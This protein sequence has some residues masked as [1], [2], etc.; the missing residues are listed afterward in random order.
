MVPILPNIWSSEW[1]GR[2]R[3]CFWPRLLYCRNYFHVMFLHISVVQSRKSSQ[4]KKS[5]FA[6]FET[7]YDLRK[8]LNHRQPALPSP[9]ISLKVQLWRNLRTLYD[10]CQLNFWNSRSDF[11]VFLIQRLTS[12]YN[13]RTSSYSF[14]PWIVSAHLCTEVKGHST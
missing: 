13:Y 2:R 12:I 11:R 8:K 5:N 1:K 3:F 4:E 7:L 9:W 6:I 10:G 14:R